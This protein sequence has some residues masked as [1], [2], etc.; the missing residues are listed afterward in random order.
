MN[1]KKFEKFIS[2]KCPRWINYLYAH[3]FNYFWMSCSLCGR[4]FGGHEWF[5]GND[6]YLGDG[7]GE[8]VCPKC[9]KEKRKEI[10]EINRK[11]LNKD[12][13]RNNK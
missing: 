8:G 7:G 10:D 11:S 3:I 2:K 6:I 9:G 5:S 1:K 4:N 12:N 13:E